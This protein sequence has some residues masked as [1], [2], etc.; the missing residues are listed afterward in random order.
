M[1]ALGGGL[2]GREPAQAPA[3]LPHPRLECLYTGLCASVCPRVPVCPRHSLHKHSPHR[4]QPHHVH[5]P[6][7][8]CRLWVPEEGSLV[9]G[10]RTWRVRPPANGL[11]LSARCAPPSGSALASLLSSNTAGSWPQ[12]L[13]THRPPRPGEPPL[14]EA[15]SSVAQSFALPSSLGFSEQPESPPAGR[16]EQSCLDVSVPVLSVEPG[17]QE[18]L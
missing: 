12:G 18:A 2:R 7:V 3:S 6:R 10:Q 1:C 8:R 17:T 5:P 13:C 9:G 11:L 4:P 15:C 14:Q 16:V